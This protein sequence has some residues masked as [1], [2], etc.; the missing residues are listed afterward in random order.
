MFIFKKKLDTIVGPHNKH[1]IED[2][3]CSW[4][5]PLKNCLDAVFFGFNKASYILEIRHFENS[6]RMELR[7]FT[8]KKSSSKGKEKE[9]R[10]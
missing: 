10:E 7:K 9:R 6:K 1:T 4:T 8:K 5:T 3:A 2:Q